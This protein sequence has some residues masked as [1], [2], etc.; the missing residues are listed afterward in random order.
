MTADRSKLYMALML[1]LSVFVDLAVV[2]FAPKVFVLGYGL[3]ILT[4]L[5]MMWGGKKLNKAGN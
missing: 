2:V 5:L 4:T 3:A 1:L